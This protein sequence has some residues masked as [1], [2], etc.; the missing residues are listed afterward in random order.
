MESEEKMKV[1]TR[2]TVHT[3]HVDQKVVVDRLLIE[4]GDNKG[5]V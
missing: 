2:C 4:R 1:E 5:E 3:H